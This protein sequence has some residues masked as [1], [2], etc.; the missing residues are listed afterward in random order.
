MKSEAIYNYNIY[1][2]R[3][4]IITSYIRKIHEQENVL[5]NAISGLHGFKVYLL[6]KMGL[7]RNF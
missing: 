5:G 3:K 4:K 2:V 7:Y 6:M 1:Y